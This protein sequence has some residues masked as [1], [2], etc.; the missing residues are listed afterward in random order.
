MAKKVTAKFSAVIE[1][2]KEKGG[3][4]LATVV[5]QRPDG[6][7][8]FNSMEPAIGVSEVTAWK[9]ASAA[10][11]WVKMMVQSLTPRKSVK[12]NAT[13]FGEKEKPVAFSGSMEFKVPSDYKFGS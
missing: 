7:D 1:L 10:K 9:N 11:R 2:N 6:S 5:A 3:A 13:K 4:W 8:G 12:M